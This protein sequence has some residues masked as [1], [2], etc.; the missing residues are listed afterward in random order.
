VDGRDNPTR[1]QTWSAA[2]HGWSV[3]TEWWATAYTASPA[4]LPG[5]PGGVG[6]MGT[7]YVDGGI[8]AAVAAGAVALRFDL[9]V[10]IHTLPCVPCRSSRYAP[11]KKTAMAR[12]KI[13]QI[14]GSARVLP[15]HAR[16]SASH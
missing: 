1:E 16:H 10:G 9:E 12:S 4:V 15:D 3:V 11:T 5:T 7:A 13:M 8:A 14:G 2:S 6:V